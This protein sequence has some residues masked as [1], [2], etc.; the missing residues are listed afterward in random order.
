MR[1]YTLWHEG[2]PD[3][4][5]WILDAVDQYT[6]DSNGEFP[7]PYLKHR[8]DVLVRELIIDISDDAVR[9]LFS[10]PTVRAT[11]IR[12]AQ[13]T[14]QESHTEPEPDELLLTA[15]EFGSGNARQGDVI[16]AAYRL[17]ATKL[18]EAGAE[19][20]AQDLESAAEEAEKVS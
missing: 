7:P 18:R 3:E 14:G 8:A 15:R 12:D 2:D 10:A 5:P 16:A 6:V 17:A 9:A 1:V 19:Q 13:R 20:H 11:V 4:F